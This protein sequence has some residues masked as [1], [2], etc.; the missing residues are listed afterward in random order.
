MVRDG[1]TEYVARHAPKREFLCAGAGTSA[2]PAGTS[3]ADEDLDEVVAGIIE[4]RLKDEEEW[5]S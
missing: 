4:R 3:I 1:L 5:Q 2:R